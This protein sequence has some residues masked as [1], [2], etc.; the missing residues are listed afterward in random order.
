MSFPAPVFVAGTGRSGTSRIAD[1]IGEHPLIH[2]IPMETR[3]LVDPGGL[4][5]LADALTVR[6][7]PEVGEDALRRLSEFLTVRVPGRRDDRGRTVPELVGGQRYRDAV[8]R[9]WPRLVADTYDE[10]APATGFGDA[11]RPAGPF[12]PSSRRRV[13][14]RYFADRRE[15]LGILRA[16]VDTLFGGAAA[17][18]GKPTWCEKTPFNLLAMDFLWELVPGA[19]IVHITRHPVA[20]LASHLAQPWAPPTV[21]GALAYLVPIYRRWFAWRDT[22]DLTG[23]RYVEVKAEDLAADWPGQRRALFARLG[24]DDVATPSAFEAHRLAGRAHQF[25]DRTR[26]FVDEAL[27]EIVPAMGYA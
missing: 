20:V 17:D 2:R 27:G 9:L 11:D 7:D 16:L 12:A 3:F 15:L 8:H 26:G 5:D 4:R 23:R 14:P 24:V 1:I 19:T 21:D 13:V 10:P 22:V 18:A 25:D 6:Y